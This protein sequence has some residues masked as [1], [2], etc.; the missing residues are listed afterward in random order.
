T[1]PFDGLTRQI[2]V[3]PKTRS[4]NFPLVWAGGEWKLSNI[5][6]YMR[7]GAF[8]LLRNAAR[9]RDRWVRDFYLIGKDSVRPR[10]KGEAYAFLLVPPHPDSSIPQAGGSSETEPWLRYGMARLNGILV[11]G[12]AEVLRA[13]AAFTAGGLTYPVG[14][15]I[16]LMR[17]PYGAYAKALLERQHYPDIREYPGGPPRRPYDVTA[18]TLPLLMGV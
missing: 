1:I 4:W 17:Q 16:V 14:T 3:D 8:A 7:S 2:N 5:L 10:V 6:D 9:Y 11:R 12:Q 18:Q 13:R 15:E